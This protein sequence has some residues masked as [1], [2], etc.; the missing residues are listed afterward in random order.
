MPPVCA[1]KRTR[2]DACPEG[3]S[4]P[5]WGR[6][7]ASFLVETFYFQKPAPGAAGGSAPVLRKLVTVR[8][9]LPRPQAS[10]RAPRPGG[11]TPRVPTCDSA[12]CCSVHLTSRPCGVS[13]P[14]PSLGSWW[15]VSPFLG[16]RADEVTLRHT[17]SPV[18][19]PVPER[20]TL[21]SLG[22]RGLKEDVCG[23]AARLLLCAHPRRVA[24]HLPG[25]R[26]PRGD[27]AW[28]LP[29]GP[30]LQ[31]LPDEDALPAPVPCELRG[32]VC[33]DRPVHGPRPRQVPAGWPPAEGHHPHCCPVRWSHGSGPA[34]GGGWWWW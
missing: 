31:A 2:P 11:Y 7:R 17:A 18:Q 25:W 9:L 27:A 24:R 5:A 14:P 23:L 10:G 32:R 26:G 6:G 3:T 33:E 16:R 8:T 28:P 13:P 20:V 19:W 15:W 12:L 29:P 22:R 30:H 4:K 34:G 21:W 1:L